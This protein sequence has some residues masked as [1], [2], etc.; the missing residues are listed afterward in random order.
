MQSAALA[1]ASPTVR[2]Q[3]CIS[4]DHQAYL[5]DHRVAGRGL[6]PAAAFLE[7]GSSALRLLMHD[8]TSLPAVCG[9]A[10]TS[11]FVLPSTVED[12]TARAVVVCSVD[13]LSGDLEIG[14]RRLGGPAAPP[15]LSVQSDSHHHHHHRCR[16][17]LRRRRGNGA[18]NGPRGSAPRPAGGVLPVHLARPRRPRRCRGGWRELR[19]LHAS[20]RPRCQPPA[21]RSFP[22]C[23]CFV[24]ASHPSRHRRLLGRVQEWPVR[25]VGHRHLQAQ[26]HVRSHHLC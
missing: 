2:F 1:S 9:A 21:R 4:V 25:R 12:G 26:E 15:H 8:A 22:R 7:V 14:S 10:I 24:Q 11:P 13:M 20:R 23:L 16:L 18:D 6:L 5:W 19:P 17:S 3:A